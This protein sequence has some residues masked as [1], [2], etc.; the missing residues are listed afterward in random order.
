M[1]TLGCT[2]ILIVF[3]LEPIYRKRQSGIVHVGTPALLVY[4]FSHTGKIIIMHSKHLT[5]KGDITLHK[6]N[7]PG[8]ILVFTNY[9]TKLFK[10]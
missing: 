3:H 8:I 5:I 10:K 9:L 6:H 4:A 7:L 2:C 1:L